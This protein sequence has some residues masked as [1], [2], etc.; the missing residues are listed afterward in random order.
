MV[1]KILFYMKPLKPMPKS[2]KLNIT[3]RFW[4]IRTF[5]R[6]SVSFDKTKKTSPIQEVQSPTKT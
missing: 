5:N 6:E 3:I 1:R 4:N 2:N